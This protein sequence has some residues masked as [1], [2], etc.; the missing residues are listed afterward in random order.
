MIKNLRT[1]SGYLRMKMI[2]FIDIMIK[3]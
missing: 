1:L 3:N 2:P